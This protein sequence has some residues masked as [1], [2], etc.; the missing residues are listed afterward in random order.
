M[1]NFLY[2]CETYLQRVVTY[3]NKTQSKYPVLSNLTSKSTIF[4][5]GII[6]GLLPFIID[7]MFI[8]PHTLKKEHNTKGEHYLILNDI[9]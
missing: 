8:A 6:V 2:R 5:A 7:R 3:W 4:L 1:V 9:V